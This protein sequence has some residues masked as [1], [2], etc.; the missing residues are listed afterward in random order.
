MGLQ[1]MP[2]C[3]FGSRGV[4]MVL[5]LSHIPLVI[6]H[7]LLP[8]NLTR[9]LCL[10]IFAVFCLK[11]HIVIPVLRYLM[12]SSGPHMAVTL[13]HTQTKH[14]MTNE[15]ASFGDDNMQLDLRVFLAPK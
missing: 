12:P 3:S 7:F 6:G 9:E 14:V 11:L 13:A 10:I 2:A 5:R 4:C 15:Q 8:Y 1:H